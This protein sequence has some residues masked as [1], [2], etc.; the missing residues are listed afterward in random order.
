MTR[1]IMQTIHVILFFLALSLPLLDS[2]FNLDST[3]PPKENRILNTLP[4]SPK[5]LDDVFDYPKNFEPYYDD[6]FGF[7]NGLLNYYSQIRFYGMNMSPIE[8]KVSLGKDGWMFYTPSLVLEQK[9]DTEQLESI[10]L[11]FESI[12]AKLARQGIPYLIVIAPDKKTIYREYVS[13]RY[14]IRDGDA[15]NSEMVTAYL[16][17]HSSVPVVD[18]ASHLKAQKE[19]GML[20]YKTDSHWNELGAF[21]ASKE[22]ALHMQPLIPGIN[23]SYPLETCEVTPVAEQGSGLANILGIA[24]TIQEPYGVKV[25]LPGGFH[26][27]RIWKHSLKSTPY[28]QNKKPIVYEQRDHTLPKAVIFRDSFSTALVPFLSEHFQRSV[29]YWQ[30]PIDYQVIENEKPDI[31]IQEIVGREFPLLYKMSLSTINLDEDPETIAE[32]NL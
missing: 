17:E 19:I 20:Y 7:R 5:N 22:I 6:H 21:L 2:F 13:E 4:D 8:E 26:S 25:S 31:V 10:R 18:L 27:R 23:Q 14:L 3:E 28:A 32:D 29:Y 9:L 16:K 24:K 30:L 15:W 1:R 12:Q 11:Y